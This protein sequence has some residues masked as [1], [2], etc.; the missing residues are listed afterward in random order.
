VEITV[1]SAET[2]DAT[3]IAAIYNQGIEERQ[4]TFQTRLHDAEDFLERITGERPF[5]V[6]EANG[7]LLGWATV[8]PYSDPAPYYAGV[9]EATMYIARTAR[10]QGVGRRLLT[11]LAHAAERSGFYKLV[12]KIFTSNRP[13]IELITGLGFRAVGVHRRHG[14]LDGEWKDVLVVELLIGEAE[15]EPDPPGV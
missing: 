10:R 9:G 12:G 6:A 11:E 15:A 7:E 5:L 1:R 13:S 4:A 2:R 3:A 8:L 14:R